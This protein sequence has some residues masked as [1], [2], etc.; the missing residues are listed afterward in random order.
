MS[1]DITTWY[2]IHSSIKLINKLK[3][4]DSILPESS[5]VIW[6]GSL[7]AS[8]PAIYNTTDPTALSSSHPYGSSKRFIELLHCHL[9]SHPH[10]QHY[11]LT[12]PGLIDSGIVVPYDPPIS[13]ILQTIKTPTFYL[14]RACG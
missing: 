10:K 6:S 14:A 3:R 11:F 12:H 2:H 5:K 8:I 9:T 1:L 13:N 7:E 4:L